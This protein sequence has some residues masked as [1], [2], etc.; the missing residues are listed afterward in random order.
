MT[1][2]DILRMA[3]DADMLF[4]LLSD[5]YCDAVDLPRGTRCRI[6][7]V[8]LDQIQRFAAMVA[9]AERR[10]LLARQVPDGWV[11]VPEHPS[12]EMLNDVAEAMGMKSVG[13]AFAGWRKM[14]CTA[15]DMHK[16]PPLQAVE[17]RM[18]DGTVRQMVFIEGSGMMG[19]EM[20]HSVNGG[21]SGWWVDIGL[22]EPKAES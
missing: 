21:P 18:P 9:D 5:A 22:A 12:R 20:S 14:L 13:L 17:S 2:A 6:S 4:A 8:S 15:R 16:R 11:M 7:D 1:D 10:E 19:N 3:A